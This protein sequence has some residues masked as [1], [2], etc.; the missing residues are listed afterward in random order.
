MKIMS[1]NE[2]MNY[3]ESFDLNKQQKIYMKMPKWALE[4]GLVN[5]YEYEENLNEIINLELN[6]KPTLKEIGCYKSNEIVIEHY[7]K[8]NESYSFLYEY[9]EL[10][11]IIITHLKEAS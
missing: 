11:I 6:V 3:E 2:A 10:K 4:N 1:K 7:E 5:K 8:D 9:G